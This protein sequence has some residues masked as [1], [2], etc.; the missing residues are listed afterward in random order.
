MYLVLFRV[1]LD[2]FFFWF[3]RRLG[4]WSWVILATFPCTGQT[5]VFNHLAAEEGLAQNTVLAVTQDRDGFIWLG[6][7]NGL[8]RFDSREFRNFRHDGHT[9]GAISSDYVRALFCTRGGALWVGTEHGLNR[10]DAQTGRFRIFLNKTGDANTLSNN[11]VRCMAEDAAGNLWVGTAAGLNRINFRSEAVR[12]ARFLFSKDAGK[13]VV[14]DVKID[15]SGNVWAGTSGGLVRLSF[16]GG[17]T[18]TTVFAPSRF[19]SPDKD[20]RAVWIDGPMVWAGTASGGLNRFSIRDGRFLARVT[21]FPGDSSRFPAIQAIAK[22]QDGDLW[23]GTAHGLYQQKCGADTFVRH[24]RNPADGRTLSDD[25]IFSAYCDRQGIMWFGTYYGGVNFTDRGIY[26]FRT[27]RIDHRGELGVVTRIL[28]RP[29]GDL[30]LNSYSLGAFSVN[31]KGFMTSPVLHPSAQMGRSQTIYLDRGGNLWQGGLQNR[32]CRYDAG[33]GEKHCFTIGGSAD[34]REERF[35]YCMLE[36]SRGRFW[37]GTS[38]D[39]LFLFDTRTGTTRAYAGASQARV[40]SVVCMMEDRYGNVWFG[41]SRGVGLISAGTSRVEWH[42]TIVSGHESSFKG[43]VNCLHEGPDGHIWAGTF[44]DGLK[45]FDPVTNSFTSQADAVTVASN[46]IT[47]VLSD[48]SGFLWMSNDLGLIRWHP[49]KNVAQYYSMSDGL[50]GQEIVTGSAFGDKANRMYFGTNQGVFFF[51]PR[52]IQISNRPP[53]VFFTGLRVFNK[54]V[55]V[56]DDRD[57]LDKDIAH[58]KEL[59]LGHDEAVFTVDFAVLNYMRA[60][61]NRFSYKL[62]GFDNA[63]NYAK[64][65]SVTYTSL[66]PGQYVLLAKGANHDGI[67]SDKPAR[68]KITILP[69][70]YYAWWAFVL[71]ILV[72][73]TA[74]FG[75]FRFLWIRALFR[76]DHELYHAKLDFF[77]NI[78]HEINTHL[79]LIQ[80]PVDK[81]ITETREHA[82]AQKLLEY[83]KNSSQQLGSLVSELLDFRKAE[84][85]QMPLHVSKGNLVAFLRNIHQSFQTTAGERQMNSLFCAD[86]DRIDLWFDP[87]QLTKVVFNLLTNAFKFTPDGGTVR[88]DVREAGEWAYIRVSDN[89]KGISGLHLPKLFVN[90]FQ[91]YEYGGQSTGYGIGLALAKRITELHGGTLSVE[92][93]EAKNGAEGRTVFTVR[94]LR[95]RAHFKQEQLVFTDE[96]PGALHGEASLHEPDVL[97][98]PQECSKSSILIVEDNELLGSFIKSTLDASYDVL[99]VLNGLAGWERATSHIPD[100]VVSDI[101]LPEMDGLELC[102]RL[103]S[104]E[105]TSHIPV[106]LL[107]AL[108]SGEHNIQGLATGADVYLTKPLNVRILELTI[109]NL[110]AARETMRA[111]FA[112]NITFEPVPTE[113]DNVEEQFLRKIIQITDKHMS[114]PGFGVDMLAREVGMSIPV[115][116]KKLKST[117]GLSVN[118]FTKTLRLKKAAQLLEEKRLNVNEVALIVGYND[119]RYFTREFR[120]AYGMPPSDVRRK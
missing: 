32:L 85:N 18:R 53:D 90:F 104:D 51:N 117:T 61:K 102:K 3:P 2:F 50:P 78:S 55:E 84:S 8:S 1:T 114:D 9:R 38:M 54:T 100:L 12:I 39:G 28:R 42:Q 112:R 80:G 62:E 113:P 13:N 71:Y 83:V 110:L 77:T 52:E 103:K 36:D 15:S 46:N 72:A 60:S 41:T 47:N 10:Y 69:P 105:R 23:V 91:V 44:Y 109:R 101:M 76:K 95:G 21:P 43:A 74:L 49:K 4:W 5:F 107:T 118:D 97:Q 66:P 17:R 115:L 19:A 116:Y 58:T 68:L 16:A 34:N 25:A 99:H 24:L 56:G 93:T 111:K 7:P 31:D 29:T 86:Q 22:G 20:V 45:R 33:T 65:P 81:L 11:S 63:W 92:S 79:S 26:P 96:Q 73:A 27:L 37:V 6:T 30:L 82:G 14:H 48:E 88:L 59:V 70:W 87:E 108:T 67:W 98:P 89:G 35:V 119:R 40:G 75:M 94:L 64:I 120:K 57:I 106:I